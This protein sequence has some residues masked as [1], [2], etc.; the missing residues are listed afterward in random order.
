MFYLYLYHNC[1]PTIFILFNF[2]LI[3]YYNKILIFDDKKWI[4]LIDTISFEK[5]NDLCNI[6]NKWDFSPTIKCNC[7][8]CNFIYNRECVR[9]KGYSLEIENEKKVL[10]YHFY[11]FEYALLN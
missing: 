5:F 4:K 7:S 9:I 8:K 1:H 2:I 11:C 10:N 3:L 6:C